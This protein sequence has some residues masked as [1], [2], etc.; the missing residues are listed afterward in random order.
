M[1]IVN[2]GAEKVMMPEQSSATD[3][4]QAL[5][6]MGCGESIKNQYIGGNKEQL[7]IYE[8]CFLDKHIKV[9]TQ[10]DAIKVVSWML[11]L[12][13]NKASIERLVN[14]DNN[15]AQGADSVP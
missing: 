3:L 9:Y 5:I 10:D 13:C 8:V 2:K 11:T 12:G 1:Y 4:I 7:Q 15:A 14:D 6:I